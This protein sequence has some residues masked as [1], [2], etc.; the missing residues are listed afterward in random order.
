MYRSEYSLTTK[1]QIK[2]KELNENKIFFDLT[3]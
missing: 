2:Q 3:F 1:L